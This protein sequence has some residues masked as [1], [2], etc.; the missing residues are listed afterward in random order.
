MNKLLFIL[1]VA[2]VVFPACKYDNA[3][4]VQKK[5]LLQITF[6]HKMGSAPF[7]ANTSYTNVFGENFKPEKFHYYCSNIELLRNGQSIGARE[8]ESYH[9]VKAGDASTETFLIKL[10]ATGCDAI[11]FLIG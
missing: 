11:S 2:I 3:E 7:V 6:T 9:L 5:Y 8:A 10:P 1:V 4:T